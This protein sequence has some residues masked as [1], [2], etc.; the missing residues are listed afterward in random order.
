MRSIDQGVSVLSMQEVCRLGLAESCAAE[1][2]EA[3]SRDAKGGCRIEGVHT[4]CFFGVHVQL[5]S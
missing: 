1:C 4:R 5:R 3:V 2:N